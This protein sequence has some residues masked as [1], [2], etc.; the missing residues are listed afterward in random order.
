MHDS[1]Y[2]NEI[3]Q[4]GTGTIIKTTGST[5]TRKALA[6]VKDILASPPINGVKSR[7]TVRLLEK[8]VGEVVDGELQVTRTTES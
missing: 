1:D 2:Q 6:E 7:M 3:T 4:T 8:E 5:S